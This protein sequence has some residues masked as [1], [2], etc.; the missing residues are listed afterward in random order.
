MFVI[1]L[2]L[3]PFVTW[4]SWR[5][6]SLIIHNASQWGLQDI[7]N[8]RSSHTL[9]TPRGGGAAVVVASLA[10]FL[11]AMFGP[12]SPHAMNG[13]GAGH[14][15]TPPQLFQNAFSGGTPGLLAS[16]GLPL[17]A[18]AFV[19]AITGLWDDIKPLR[20]RDR[21]VAQAFAVGLLFMTIGFLTGKPLDMALRILWDAAGIGGTWEQFLA[22]GNDGLVLVLK[23]SLVA[24]LLA[25]CIWWVNLFNFMDGIDGIAASQALFMLLA[26]V[27]IRFTDFH[28]VEYR[29]FIP[30]I[31]PHLYTSQ[32]ITLLSLVVAAA[33]IGFLIHN[34]PPARIFMGDA[35][36]LFLGY[37]ILVVAAFDVASGTL[38]FLYPNG[39]LR[40]RPP[41]EPLAGMLQPLCVWLILGATFIT[42]ATLTLLRRLLRGENPGT[43]HRS[44]AY[45][46]LSRYYGSHRRATLVYCLI[47][48]C[49]LLPLAIVAT[50]HPDHAAETMIIAYLPLVLLAWHFGAGREE[51]PSRP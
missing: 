29:L 35:G 17:F 8:H 43:P 18:G 33:L 20:V 34:W 50:V 32:T 6:T 27:L 9:P 19:L 24:I 22:A 44:H 37:I 31:P 14:G 2:L 11:M 7:P 21:L 5:A 1:L 16:L 38:G 3:L 39:V 48:L 51:T 42:D 30:H 15:L 47:N 13:Q 12:W 10:G 26:G 40:M 49:W 4:L 36:S 23:A 41:P 45:Q 25:G 28:L 46:R